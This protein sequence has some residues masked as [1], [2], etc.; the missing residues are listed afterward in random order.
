MKWSEQMRVLQSEDEHYNQ[1]T[2]NI[3]EK[4]LFINEE[5]IAKTSTGYIPNLATSSA[6]IV[7]YDDYH[8]IIKKYP[9]FTDIKFLF[10][11]IFKNVFHYT[12]AN[13]IYYYDKYIVIQNFDSTCALGIYT[14]PQVTP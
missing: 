14:Q 11:C 7:T 3:N 2:L 10:N 9:F 6:H 13:E 4:K 12:K 8:K 1:L 5:F